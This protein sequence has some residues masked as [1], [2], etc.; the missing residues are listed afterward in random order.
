MSS[1]SL[2]DRTFRRPIDW[3]SGAC[4]D[5][6]AV[7][8]I[9]EDAL[10]ERADIGLWAV[11]DGMGGHEV[12]DV[13]SRMIVERLARLEGNES[14]SDFVDMVEE[15][16]LDVNRD[17]LDYADVMFDKA[18]MGSTLVA[19]VIRG[20]VGVCLWAGDSRLYRLR[21]HQ[22]TQLSRD[23]SHVQEL[24]EMG[25][26]EPEEAARHPNANI[27]TR[28]IGVEEDGF[29]DINVFNAQIGDA[30]LLCSDGLH[31][32]VPEADLS[33]ILGGRDTRL[34]AEELVQA[35]LAKGAPDNVS[36]VVVRGEPGKFG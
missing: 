26:L 34:M 8:A 10:V 35:S 25:A 27:I 20:R 16:L 4:T 30:F 7:R 14:L 13:A 9:N 15:A 23:H 1:N 33:R 17:I 31:N 28:A 32:M 29:I 6:G 22:L 5:V 18:T 11:A 19:L 36:V 3:R 12:G 21:N 2:N 24:I